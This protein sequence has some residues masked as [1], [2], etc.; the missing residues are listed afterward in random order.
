MSHRTPGP[1]TPYTWH[2]YQEMH[3]DM[4]G[5]SDEQFDELV[6]ERISEVTFEL[7]QHGP[8]VKL[9]V[10]HD[11]FAGET[12]MYRAISSGWP[13][14][15]ARLKTMLETGEVPDWQAEQGPTRRS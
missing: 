9:T 7:E 5:W 11:G 8:M 13:L 15:I 2:N 4:F 3:K 10:I 6:K 14:I 1:L 12:E